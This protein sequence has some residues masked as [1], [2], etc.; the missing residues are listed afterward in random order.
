MG[1]YGCYQAM[2]EESRLFRRLR[3]ERALCVMYASSI[4]QP[5]GP[6]DI[7]HLPPSELAD[8]LAEIAK[9]PVFGSRAAVDRVFADLQAEL[10]SAAEEYPGLPHRAAY[11]KLSDFDEYLAD[12]LANA[13]RAD[14]A[15]LTHQIVMGTE[16]FAPGMFGRGDM[17][18]RVVPS[19][20][21]AEAAGLLRN[22]GPEQ[23]PGWEEEWEAFRSVYIEAAAR[24]E[25][26]VIAV[27]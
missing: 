7:A 14:A 15:A 10:L 16:S 6:Y 18:L 11:F 26:I 4:H 12:A 9:E 21:V 8:Y 17:P 23:F 20:L 19:P 25:A 27:G 1:A 3:T 2:P 5:R 24:R 13:G 22:I